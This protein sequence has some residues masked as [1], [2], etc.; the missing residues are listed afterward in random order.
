MVCS[1]GHQPQPDPQNGQNPA[2]TNNE[3]SQESSAEAEENEPDRTGRDRIK[4]NYGG[5]Y[6]PKKKRKKPKLPHVCVICKR[7]RPRNLP[8]KEW[9]EHLDGEHNIACGDCGKDLINFIFAF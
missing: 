8:D 7:S 2:Q 9:R 1:Q 4:G 6:E 5:L 3:N